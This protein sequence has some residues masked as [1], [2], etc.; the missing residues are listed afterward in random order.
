[1]HLMLVVHCGVLLLHPRLLHCHRAGV[2]TWW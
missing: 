1:M 2:R